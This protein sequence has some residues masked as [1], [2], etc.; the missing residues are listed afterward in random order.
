MAGAARGIAVALTGELEVVQGTEEA[1]H[2]LVFALRDSGGRSAALEG[3][4][5]GVGRK[6]PGKV[7]VERAFAGWGDE[8]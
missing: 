4:A 3:Q 5:G 7:P 8:G 2:G 6:V 1:C